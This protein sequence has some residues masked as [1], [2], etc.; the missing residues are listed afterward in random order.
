MADGLFTQPYDI[1]HEDANAIVSLKELRSVQTA[2]ET[3]FIR[4]ILEDSKLGDTC[5]RLID[6]YLVER[7]LPE[8]VVRSARTD[9]I[10]LRT[11]LRISA[12]EAGADISHLVLRTKLAVTTAFQLISAAKDLSLINFFWNLTSSCPEAKAILVA[13][14]SD[15]EKANA[16]RLIAPD[17]GRDIKFLDLGAMRRGSRE[18]HAI[19]PEIAAFPS[20]ETLSL[21]HQNIRALT[22]ELARLTQLKDLFLKNTPL[23]KLTRFPRLPNLEFVSISAEV[24][25]RHVDKMGN[26]QSMHLTDVHK[27]SPQFQE[28]LY[29]AFC[30]IARD[31]GIDTSDP[32]FG[33]HT[34]EEI[35]QNYANPDDGSV[36]FPD[37][38]TPA[39]LRSIAEVRRENL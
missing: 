1:T 13:K 10:A 24:F 30:A 39:L 20:L 27:F 37:T 35:V 17:F 26:L 14:T 9:A 33:R 2:V 31:R 19:P 11:Q 23:S 8:G 15:K 36:R 4:V 3:C 22:P 21:C 32:A 16:L 7:P 38:A 34:F 5:E 12:L 28:T 25:E 29:R 18:M 6:R